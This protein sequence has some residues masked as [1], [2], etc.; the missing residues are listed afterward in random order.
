MGRAAEH[1]GHDPKEAGKKAAKDISEGK[2]SKDELKEKY[3]DAK[4]RGQGDDFK[5]GYAE[6]ADEV[7]DG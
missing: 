7:F 1:F 3:K 6:G 5:K 4:F 2:I